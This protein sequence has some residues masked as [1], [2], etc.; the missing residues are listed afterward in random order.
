MSQQESTKQTADELELMTEESR[1]G[2]QQT[3]WGVFVALH[4]SPFL[5][6]FIDKLIPNINEYVIGLLTFGLSAAAFF[7]TKTHFGWILVGIRWVIDQKKQPEFPFITFSAKP[8]PFVSTAFNSNLFWVTLFFSTVATI[9][10]T[11]SYL[12][13]PKTIVGLFLAFSSTLCV[14][15]I[16]F[17]IRCHNV[18]KSQSD[19]QARTVLL[20]TTAEF[21][22]VD[23][24][25]EEDNGSSEQTDDQKNGNDPEN[26]QVSQ[27]SSIQTPKVGIPS[28]YNTQTVPSPESSKVVPQQ[29]FNPTFENHDND[30]D[31]IE[32]VKPFIP[33]FKSSTPKFA[34]SFG[35]IPQDDQPQPAF[36]PP[37]VT[38]N[39]VP[40]FETEDQNNGFDDMPKFEPTFT[41]SFDDNQ[42]DDSEPVHFEAGN[43]DDNEFLAAD[44]D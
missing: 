32:N 39:S 38:D 27:H 7:L 6:L 19:R 41:P 33:E 40:V 42:Q 5:I 36:E 21:E 12:L 1:H 44:E 2:E 25:D 22:H 35:D 43:D 28:S 24:S 17:F 14:I 37:K 31:Q 30:D 26:P 3:H 13:G 11:I 8:L 15:N 29:A 20:D 16:N 18:A 10:S 4:L 9:L 23:D 34:P